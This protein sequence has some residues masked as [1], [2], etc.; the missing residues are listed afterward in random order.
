MSGCRMAAPQAGG[1]SVA[2]V[3]RGGG[4]AGSLSLLHHVLV[5]CPE[6]L[7]AK[8]QSEYRGSK[9]VSGKL[10]LKYEYQRIVLKDSN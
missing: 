7:Q 6:H 2:R 4:G 5:W 9:N 10:A 8:S 1:M 3:G